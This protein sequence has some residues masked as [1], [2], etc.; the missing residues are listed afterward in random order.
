MA[1]AMHPQKS[2]HM[3]PHRTLTQKI[4]IGMG[5]VFLAIGVVGIVMPALLGLHLSFAHNLIH[6]ASG[7]LAMWAGYSE[8]PRMSYNFSVGFGVIYGLLGL[9]GF[10]MGEP[11][12]PGVGYM[13]ADEN[14]MR[15]IP[16]A[17]EFGTVDHTAHILFSVVFLG[18][19]YL[20]KRKDDLAG[21][22]IVK[23][24]ARSYSNQKVEPT[25]RNVP[26]SESGLKDADLGRLDINRKNDLE[27]RS[28]FENRV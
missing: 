11:G 13:E 20:W 12:Y 3:L 4:C 21:K 2:H 1:T 7:A 5:L 17:L 15:I 14:L 6:L 16:N 25:F 19:A 24:Q 26:D 22:I 18:T 23:N 8:E 10:I 9:A 27:R 28:D